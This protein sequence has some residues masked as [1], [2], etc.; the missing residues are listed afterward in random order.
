MSESVA[1]LQRA[2]GDLRALIGQLDEVVQRD[3]LLGEHVD[4]LT[5]NVRALISVAKQRHAR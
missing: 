1:D 4:D 2:L 3:K 5:A